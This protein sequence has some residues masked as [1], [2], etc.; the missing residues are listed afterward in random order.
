MSDAQIFNDLQLSEQANDKLFS[1][2]KKLLTIFGLAFFLA[3]ASSSAS[4]ASDLGF[5]VSGIGS[6]A[7]ATRSSSGGGGLLRCF[8]CSTAGDGAGRQAFVRL[9]FFSDMASQ[10]WSIDLLTTQTRI[11]ISLPG[12]AFIL[13]PRLCTLC[14]TVIERQAAK[15]HRP[16]PAMTKRDETAKKVAGNLM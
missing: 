8:C 12:F 15:R 10:S 14:Q 9:D 5:S 2:S 4:S 6:A 13:R 3:G 7:A 11:Q 16:G 1:S